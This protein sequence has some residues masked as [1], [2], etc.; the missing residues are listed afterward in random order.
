MERCVD[1]I[2][3]LLCEV[4]RLFFDEVE[5]RVVGGSNYLPSMLSLSLRSSD[6]DSQW[7]LRSRPGVAPLARPVT[8]ESVLE[9]ERSW[10]KNGPVVWVQRGGWAARSAYRVAFRVVSTGR[11]SDCIHHQKQIPNICFS[12]RSRQSYKHTK[13][14]VDRTATFRGTRLSEQAST[15]LN[16]AVTWPLTT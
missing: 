11:L 12:G 3:W 13:Y 15:F 5:Y 8:A 4:S 6:S 9:H 1:E 10:A 16:L 7:A 2:V 14:W